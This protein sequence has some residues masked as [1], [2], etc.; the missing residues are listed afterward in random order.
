MNILQTNGCKI[1]I[2]KKLDL[3]GYI[4]LV[5]SQ[6]YNFVLGLEICVIFFTRFNGL[7]KIYRKNQMQINI[8]S[9]SKLMAF[10]NCFDFERRFIYYRIVNKYFKN[11]L[12][13]MSFEKIRN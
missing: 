11:I 10:N 3:L 2:Y 9:Y 8:N 4:S 12:G 7:S 6:I 13:A 5:V 1:Y